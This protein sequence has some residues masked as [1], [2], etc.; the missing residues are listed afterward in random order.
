MF[1]AAVCAPGYGDALYDP[2]TATAGPN[3]TACS[4]GYYGAPSRGSTPCTACPDTASYFFSWPPGGDA[5]IFRPLPT[6]P[7]G[8][9]SQDACLADF[10]QIVDGPFYVDWDTA[11]ADVVTTDQY[12]SLASCVVYCRQSAGCAGVTFNYFTFNCTTWIPTTNTS[13][14]SGVAIKTLPSYAIAQSVE[15]KDMG[16]GFYTFWKGATSAA[17]LNINTTAVAPTMLPE[18]LFGCGSVNEC[19]GVAYQGLNYTDQTITA[20]TLLLGKVVPGDARRS[21]LK[22]KY[23][24]LVPDF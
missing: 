15:A 22:A 19:V 20:C 17:F 5:E 21:L 2:T 9:A 7:V 16:T 10:G 14:T 8:A 3:C 4:D 18:C 12:Q 11:N 6:S 13:N 1:A 23:T 24:A